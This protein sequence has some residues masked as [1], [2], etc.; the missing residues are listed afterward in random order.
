MVQF[1]HECEGHS[2][3]IQGRGKHSKETV[4][5]RVEKGKRMRQL[6]S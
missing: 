4:Q 2:S 5:R 3:E 1:G 6:V